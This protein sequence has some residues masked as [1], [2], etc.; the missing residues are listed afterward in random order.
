MYNQYFVRKVQIG[1]NILLILIC[2]TE[3]L[4]IGSLDLMCNEFKTNFVKVDKFI[5]DINN[6]QWIEYTIS[7]KI[8]LINC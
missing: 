3:S 8:N 6:K 4:D 2:E 1:K 5:E 7:N